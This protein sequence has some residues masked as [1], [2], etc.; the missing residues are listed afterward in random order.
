MT[1]SALLATLL[2]GCSGGEPGTTPGDS[3]DP[4]DTDTDT[5][6][7]DTD[8]PTVADCYPGDVVEPMELDEVLAPYGWPAAIS[9]AT[10]DKLDIDLMQVPC[11]SDPDIDWSPHDVL[12]FVSIPAW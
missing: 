6:D 10:G 12:V 2:F 7:T 3:D 5:V 4:S 11:A 9:R 8:P 1:R